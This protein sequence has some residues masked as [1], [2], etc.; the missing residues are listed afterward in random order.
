MI[1]RNKINASLKTVMTETTKISGLSEDML[2]S[3]KS[4]ITVD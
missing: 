3:K 1:K 2:Q 4:V